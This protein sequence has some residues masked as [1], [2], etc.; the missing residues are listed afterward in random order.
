MFSIWQGSSE[1]ETLLQTLNH[2]T[3]H[4]DRPHF[5]CELLRSG[6]YIFQFTGVSKGNTKNAY[7]PIYRLALYYYANTRNPI[8]SIFYST[9]CVLWCRNLC[10]FTYTVSKIITKNKVFPHI[11]KKTPQR[12]RS[13]VRYRCATS[14]LIDITSFNATTGG[15]KSNLCNW[16]FVDMI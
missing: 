1:F 3:K 2:I 11:K 10:F 15:A 9:R 8:I 13:R 5:V 16:W 14:V 7:K 6:K 4:I 12:H